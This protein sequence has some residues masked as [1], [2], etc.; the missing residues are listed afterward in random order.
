MKRIFTLAVALA[1][2]GLALTAAAQ[3][4]FFTGRLVRAQSVTLAADNTDKVLVIKYLGSATTASVAVAAAGDLTFLAGGAAVTEFECPVAG[5]LGGVITVSDGACNSLGEVADVINASTNW[6]AYILDGFRADAIDAN[7]FLAAAAA[8][9][10][11]KAGAPIYRETATALK[12]VRTL[13]HCR[14]FSCLAPAGAIPVNPMNNRYQV[15]QN[16]NVKSTY[17][18]GTSVINIYTRKRTKNGETTALVWTEAGGNTTVYNAT[19]AS[20]WPNGLIS[21][22]GEELVI[23]VVNDNSMSAVLGQYNGLLFDLN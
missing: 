21:G 10:N 7:S 5:A 1:A 9:A 15:L 18:G 13:T 2:V 17:G 19:G 14:D 4:S 8:D 20:D 3:S 11:S 12:S 22:P 23:A 16:I 6:R